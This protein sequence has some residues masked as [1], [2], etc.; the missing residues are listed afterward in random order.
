MGPEPHY[1][2]R[3]TAVAPSKAMCSGRHAESLSANHTRHR[4]MANHLT[5]QHG[6]A[7]LGPASVSLFFKTDLTL[8]AG[9]KR[10][11]CN[12]ITW[13]N[14]IA[15]H[16]TVTWTL[17]C[18]LLA[19]LQTRAG[20]CHVRSLGYGLFYFDHWQRAFASLSNSDAG[21]PGKHLRRHCGTNICT[22]AMRMYRSRHRPAPWASRPHSPRL[23]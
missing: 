12:R 14:W 15:P 8:V 4:L 6:H 1:C 5:T 18:A 19:K 21:T 16:R 20:L 9:F 7:P 11:A 2:H 17:S 10:R 13:G 3:V 22:A 23:V